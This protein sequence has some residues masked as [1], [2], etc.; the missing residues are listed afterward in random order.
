MARYFTPTP[1]QYI[2]QFV[3]PNLDLM[4]KVGQEKASMDAA[5]TDS[6]DKAESDWTVK[7]GL[8]SNK[9]DVNLFNEEVKTNLNKIRDA[10]YND[11]IDAPQAARA[12]NRLQNTVKTNNKYT[13]YKL[14]EA[15]TKDFV[16][17]LPT[18]VYNQGLGVKLNNGLNSIDLRDGKL[19]PNAQIDPTT[20]S[21]EQL[22]NWY[23]VTNPG[24]FVKE[25]EE[26]YKQ[27]NPILTQA[28]P[29]EGYRIISDPNT[30]ALIMVN[31]NE[32]Y[33]TKEISKEILRPYIHNYAKQNYNSTNKPSVEYMRREGKNEYDYENKL[34]DS[35]IGYGKYDEKFGDNSYSIIGN[36]NLNSQPPPPPPDSFPISGGDVEYGIVKEDFLDLDDWDDLVYYAFKKTKGKDFDFTKI[37][38][39]NS[40]EYKLL[41][42]A[43]Q[44]GEATKNPYDLSDRSKEVLRFFMENKPEWQHLLPYLDKDLNLSTGRKRKLYGEFFKAMGMLSEDIV[45]TD[46]TAYALKVEDL[47]FINYSG[48]QGKGA[49]AEDVLNQARSR[50]AE[51]YSVKDKAN[52]TSDD[53]NKLI[54][55]NGKENLSS[56]NKLTPENML[57]F[58]TGNDNFIS[59]VSISIGGNQYYIRNTSPTRLD[60]LI[61]KMYNKGKLSLGLP[62]Q[63][64]FPEGKL[65]YQI[66]KDNKVTLKSSK[67]NEQFDSI[68]KML[69]AI[70]NPDGT[71]KKDY[72]NK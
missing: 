69:M 31:K 15:M 61:N 68:T 16:S 34:L 52:L 55:S 11:Q 57:P 29:N 2:S 28:Y 38:D 39:V 5:L 37:G 13:L 71:I 36:K 49:K 27:I 23:N 42:T 24:E 22:S 25:H 70:I 7:G 21:I 44:Y 41:N 46:Q 45:R 17:K 65:N 1:S 60:A 50:G 66:D 54:T 12:L 40:D 4:Y 8:F 33:I 59:G 47:E 35:F 53:I 10:F 56:I 26:I 51:I 3:P 64:E 62:V 14:D 6:L 58:L 63:Y 72:L 9:N 30:G 18:G 32:E 43:S 48:I 19:A 20:T 67:K